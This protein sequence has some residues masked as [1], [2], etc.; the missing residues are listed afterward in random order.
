MAASKSNG[1]SV[2]FTSM[3]GYS[4]DEMWCSQRWPHPT[5]Y[6]LNI[7]LERKPRFGSD[8]GSNQDVTDRICKPDRHWLSIVE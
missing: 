5:E 2:E 3:A 1:V 6:P 8:G 7:E 4:T